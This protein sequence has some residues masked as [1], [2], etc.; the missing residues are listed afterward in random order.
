MG[1]GMGTKYSPHNDLSLP[2]AIYLPWVLVYPGES[3][4][5]SQVNRH[6]IASE[7]G[8]GWLKRGHVAT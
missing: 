1:S 2:F 5:N 4:L 6:V 8:N 7:N 3:A